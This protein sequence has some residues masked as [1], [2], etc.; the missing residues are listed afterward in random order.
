MR[1]RRP[2]LREIE[3]GLL[4]APPPPPTL[5][6]CMAAEWQ[7][8]TADLQGRGLLFTSSLGAVEAYLIAMWTVR[9][10]REAIAEHGLLIR[11]KDNQLKPNP[12]NGMM[13]GALEAVGRLSSELGLTPVSRGRKA[14]QSPDKPEGESDGWADMD[15]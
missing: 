10:C 13:K 9:E 7:E 14:I 12:A 8:I 1:G 5:P 15:L 2:Q 4:K 6:K 3:G 11:A